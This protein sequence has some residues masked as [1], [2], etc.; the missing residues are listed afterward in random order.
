M[1]D[2]VRWSV[3]NDFHTQHIIIIVVVGPVDPPT[4]VVTDVSVEYSVNLS[5]GVTSFINVHVNGLMSDL[6]QRKYDSI[7]G[8]GMFACLLI[9]NL[10][11]YRMCY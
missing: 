8:T 1:S 7:S 2:N 11:F 6:G 10:Q 4:R 9:M 3:E 5:E